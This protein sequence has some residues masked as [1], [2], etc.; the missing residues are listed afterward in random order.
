MIEIN[1]QKSLRGANNDFKLHISE[2]IS[3]GDCIGVFG[4]SGSGKTT[5]LRAVAG[6]ETK[7]SGT[8]KVNNKMWNDTEQSIL[9]P[10][11]FRNIGYVTQEAVLFP[12]MSIKEQLLFAKGNLTDMVLLE[13]L[14]KVLRI[15]N[16]LNSCPKHLSGGQKQRVCFARAILQKPEILLLDEPFTGLDYLHTFQLV[17]FLKKYARSLKLTILLV[18]HAPKIISEL[19][20]QVWLLENGTVIEKGFPEKVM[21]DYLKHFR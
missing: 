14:V 1:I 15:E 10:T 21:I 5:L 9:L 18:S 19:T 7:I 2:V 13:K 17:D 20:N 12:N 4:A 6:L 11:H 3:K 16:L 8:I